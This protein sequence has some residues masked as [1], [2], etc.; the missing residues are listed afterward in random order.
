MTNSIDE[1][2]AAKTRH[3]SET[4]NALGKTAQVT[5]VLFNID[6]SDDDAHDI[7]TRYAY[8]G[9][10]N[11]RFVCTDPANN[12]VEAR[13]DVR[14]RKL[15]TIDPDLGTWSYVY[16]GYGDL[17]SQ[18]DAKQQTTTMT[19]DKLGRMLTKTDGQGTAEWVYDAAAGGV[20]KLAAMVSPP[21]SRLTGLCAIAYVAPSAN[22]AA[23]SFKYT[24]VGDLEEVTDCIDGSTFV[25]TYRYD[26]KGRQS[27]VQ[28]PNVNGQRIAVGYHYTGLGYLHYLTDESGDFSVLWQATAMNGLDQVVREVM[29][30]GVENVS[31]RNSATGWMMSTTSTAHKDGDKI[32]QDWSYGYDEGGNLLT[33][34]RA[35]EASPSRSVETFTY[36]SLNRVLTSRVAIPLESYNTP[37]SFVYDDL[38]NL[39]RKGG[40]DYAYGTCQAGP[41]AVCGVGSGPSFSYDP[42]GNLTSG[43]G[44]RV[45]Y[46]ALNKAIHMQGATGQV[47]FIYGA[48][49]NRV[50][51][52]TGAQG[53]RTVY[54]GLGATGRSLYERTTGP[55]GTQ[56]IHFIYAGGAHGGNP[57]A[58]RILAPD[59]S[60]TATKYYSFDHLGSVTALSN[61]TGQVATEGPS[62]DVFGYDPWGARRNADG[63]AA[64]PASFSPAPGHRE[65]TGHETIPNLGLVNMNG[66]VYD[67]ALG[68]LM[69]P[70]PTVQF[71]ANSQSYN[72]YSY[73]LN[74]PIRSTDPTGFLLDEYTGVS[75]VDFT[76]GMGLTIGSMAFCAAYGAESGGAACFMGNA[77]VATWQSA[78]T[79]SHG[80]SFGLSLAINGV[81]MFVGYAAG[82][83]A[84]GLAAAEAE[85]ANQFAADVAQFRGVLVSGAV[86]SS[87]SRIISTAALG[88]DLSA[89]D[90]LLSAAEGAAM[91][92]VAWGIT[93]PPI[94]R[95][96]MGDQDDYTS[97]DDVQQAMGNRLGNVRKTY[98]IPGSKVQMEINPQGRKSKRTA[99]P[100]SC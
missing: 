69:S 67:P 31:D 39:T 17:V 28:Y 77:I 76:V 42:N 32:I 11:L 18:T 72:R 95:A 58:L 45:D 30:N 1:T 8:D 13:F 85:G 97:V 90:L 75:G 5:E 4:K 74:N 98:A 99:L 54:V 35:D 60:T 48:D 89:T 23:R 93:Q 46:N 65:F 36:D 2:V 19:Y 26:S 82:G 14:G 24:S 79:A 47:D 3:K 43:S 87:L 38:G 22:R 12:V 94:S 80:G 20:G 88:R 41:H 29:R 7:T 63:R 34:S 55:S 84:F 91:G 92:A 73:V 53:E 64:D 86:S 25:T 9:D 10:G 59:G 68:R 96:S 51:Q 27:L 50:V 70:D 56:H 52:D 57:F 15:K 81:T 78:V 83:A 44:R 66:R 100:T 61:E 71:A 40:Q 21:D 16:N 33:R 62:A 6:P 37:E 49:G